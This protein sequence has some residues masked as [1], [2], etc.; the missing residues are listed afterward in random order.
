ML[1]GLPEDEKAGEDIIAYL[2]ETGLSVDE[3]S[4]YVG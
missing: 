2:R 3:V 4:D 1:L